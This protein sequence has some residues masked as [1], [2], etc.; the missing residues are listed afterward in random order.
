MASADV[1]QDKAPELELAEETVIPP[2]PQPQKAPEPRMPI[3]GAA[4]SDQVN[5]RS[6]RSA[7]VI[8]GVIAL[9]GSGLYYWQFRK[10]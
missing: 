10:K 6:F 5:N 9:F 8:L 2:V 1:S 7:L 4:V 3:T